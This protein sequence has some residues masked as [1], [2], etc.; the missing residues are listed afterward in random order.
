[1]LK[2]DEINDLN[3]ISLT[4]VRA[5]A[6]IGLLIMAP[7]SI[8][9]I[10][11]AFVDMNIMDKT[12]SNDIL[13]I[14]LNTVK[15]M[16]CEISRSSKSTQYKYVL[17]KHPFSLPVTLD[18]Y[19]ILKRVYDKIKYNA[20]IHTLIKYD[21]LFK[22]IAAFIFDNELKEAFLGISVLKQFKI[23]FLE[24]LISDCSSEKT[25]ELMYKKLASEQASRKEIIAQKI[26][27]NND[28]IYLYGYDINKKDSI[29]LNIKNIVSVLSK[30]LTDNNI[31]SK[32]LK[33]KFFMKDFGT[34]SPTDEENIIE[35]KDNGY[36]VEGHYFNDFLATQRILS[37]G[38]NCTVIEPLD[39]KNNIISKLKEMRKVYEK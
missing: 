22:K 19:K 4:G 1:M 6:L 15:A 16:G 20:D 12:Q 17:K 25:L 35:I 30:K 38:T 39:F 24:E 27:F 13:R 36:L 31:K 34:D 23:D 10:K 37:F 32:Q 28:K 11:K 14:D 8:E 33:I 26:V 21:N 9:E 2:T 7:R 3:Q 29:V 5:I 18:D